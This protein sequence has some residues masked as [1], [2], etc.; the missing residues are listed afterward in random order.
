[1]SGQLQVETVVA[2]GIV[3]DG[4]GTFGRRADVWIADGRVVQLMPHGTPLPDGASVVDAAGAWVMPGFIDLHTH[5]DAELEI[6]PSLSESLRH[7]V[8]TILVGS[9]GL[10]LAVGTA[11]DLADMFCRVEGIP[12]SSV[13]E[14]LDQVLDWDD[15][16][17]YLRHLDSVPTGPNVVALLGHSTIRAKVMGLGPSLEAGRRPTSDEMDAM[18]AMLE[19]SLDEGFLG[20][21][22]NTLPWDKMGGD[23]YRSK[24]TPSTFS[25]FSEY[26]KFMSVLRRRSRIFQGVPD[27]SGRWNLALFAAGSTGWFRPRLKTMIISMMDVKAAPGMYRLLGTFGRLVNGPMRGNLRFQSLPTPFDLTVDGMEV[28]VLEEIGAGTEALHLEDLSERSALLNDPDYRRRFMDQWGNRWAGKAYHR[29]LN[30]A[31]IIGAP[32]DKLVGKTF[33]QIA[34][35]R[36]QDPVDTF[37]DLQAEYGNDLRWFT[38]VA[39]SADKSIRRIISD[40]SVL[41]GFSDAGAHLRNMA[42]YN[43]PLRMLKLVRDAELVGDNFMSV[44]DAVKRLTSELADYLGIDAGRLTPGSRA[45]IAII[46]PEG[47]DDSLAE[48]HESTMPEFG[49]LSRMVRRNDGAVRAVLVNGRLAWDG[50]QLVDGVGVKND[51]GQVLRATA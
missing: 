20:L 28:P 5:Y 26:R 7:G 51:F 32:D 34:A 12:R 21:S 6:S 17:G 35:M 43:F 50:D 10:S 27:L 29:D 18:V 40:A 33:G 4:E 46:N 49:N 8:T 47:L 15:P 22:I 1:M 9:C 36:G 45:D 37:L 13:L 44:G 23:R 42:F 11:E 38:V 2:G 31:K 30:E 39:N 24:P 16:A 19:D 3:Y 48:L 14:I 25:T 41:I